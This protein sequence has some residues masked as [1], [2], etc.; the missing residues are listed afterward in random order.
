MVSSR[1]ASHPRITARQP[2]IGVKR[3]LNTA[4]QRQRRKEGDRRPILIY[5]EGQGA[6]EACA[7]ESH[8]SIPTKARQDTSEG[9][10]P[11]TT[12]R[13]AG[14]RRGRFHWGHQSLALMQRCGSLFSL[15]KK[16]ELLRHIPRM[17]RSMFG[18]KIKG[19]CA[20]RGLLLHGL[21]L[22]R[23]ANSLAILDISDRSCTCAFSQHTRGSRKLR[24][25]RDPLRQLAFRKD[26][27]S[28]YSYRNDLYRLC[29]QWRCSRSSLI[30][31]VD[32]T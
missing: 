25:G 6:L 5:A 30:E 21:L 2:I 24:L 16:S 15:L 32:G 17:I 3:V 8:W 9:M 23:L 27:T 12:T 11:R 20:F 26:Y 4:S 22:C 14:S 19:T 7:V 13:L 1:L 29:V 28:V 31:R 18:S 10:A